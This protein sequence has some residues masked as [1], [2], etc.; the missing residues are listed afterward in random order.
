MTDTSM[1]ELYA[2][3]MEKRQFIEENGYTYVCK[4]ECDFKHDMANNA[5]MNNTFK[6]LTLSAHLNHGMLFTVDEPKPSTCT[7]KRQQINKSNT[8]MLHYYTRLLT[9]QEKYLLV[10]HKSLLKTLKTYPIMKASLNAK[11]YRPETST[12]RY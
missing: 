6:P 12:Y 7:K 10:T 3:T 4:C 5:A 11:C 8:L 2:R 1:S 9:R